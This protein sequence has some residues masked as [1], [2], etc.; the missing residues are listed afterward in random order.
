MT[1]RRVLA[2]AWCVLLVFVGQQVGM[3]LQGRPGA[4]LVALAVTVAGGGLAWWV[5]WW[6]GEKRG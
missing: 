6:S 1:R 2:V 5:W 4:A 3:T